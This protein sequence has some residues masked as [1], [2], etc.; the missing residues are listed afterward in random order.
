MNVEPLELLLNKILNQYNREPEGWSVLIDQQRNMLVIGPDIGYKLKLIHINPQEYTGV[1]I[2]LKNLD[3]TRRAVGRMPSYGLRPLLENEANE[4]FNTFRQDGSIQHKLIDTI[5]KTKPM[6]TWELEKNKPTAILSGPIINHP[7]LSV[8]S[9][10]QRELD[11]KLHLE[12][13][14]LFR[15]KYPDRASMYT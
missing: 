13:T 2:K 8:L 10:G 15:E 6:S 5:L 9:A 7:N 12:A 11:A 1:G 4:L 3:E 14:K